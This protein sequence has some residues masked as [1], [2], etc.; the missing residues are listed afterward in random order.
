MV[1]ERVRDMREGSRS[2]GNRKAFCVQ[3]SVLRA[4]CPSEQ[5]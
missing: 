1:D 2:V 3:L 5:G 4:E